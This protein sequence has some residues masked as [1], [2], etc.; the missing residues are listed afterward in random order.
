VL[1]V[2]GQELSHVGPHAVL[3]AALVFGSAISYAVYLVLSGEEVRRIGALRLTGLAST[4]ACAL[5]IGQFLLLR[6]MSAMAVAPAVVWL[7][8]LNALLCTFAPVLM[9]M[10]AIERVGATLVAQTGMIGP[11]STLLMGV[12]LLGEPFT[13]GIAAGTVLVIAGIWLLAQWR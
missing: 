1:L 8:L 10:M 4:V 13:A 9:V 7:S 3:G 12:L 6:P 2:F 11:M 5:C